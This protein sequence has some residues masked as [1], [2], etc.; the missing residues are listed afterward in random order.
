MSLTLVL[1]VNEEY[2][3]KAVNIR[4][5]I[6]SFEDHAVEMGE[7]LPSVV[8]EDPIKTYVGYAVVSRGRVEFEAPI[9]G[10]YYL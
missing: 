1:G 4:V 10:N 5:Y 6:K 2:T 3:L 8:A 7:S 9:S